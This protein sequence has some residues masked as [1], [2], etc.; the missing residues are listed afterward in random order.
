MEKEH[1]KSEP[2]FRKLLKLGGK[3][4]ILLL[5]K[6]NESEYFTLLLIF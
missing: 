3:L 4:S 5:I 2:L 6:V 1:K